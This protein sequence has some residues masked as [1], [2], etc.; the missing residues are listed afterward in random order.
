MMS[1]A[2][3]KIQGCRLST[4]YCKLPI[5]SKPVAVSVASTQQVQA[6]MSHAVA[7]AKKATARI[8]PPA[9]PTYDIKRVIKEVLL[10][11]AG[12]RGDVT[13]IATIPPDVQ[14]EAQFLAKDSGVIAGIEMA[15]M[16]FKEVDP[17]LKVDW[18]VEDGNSLSK[19]LHFGSVFGSARSILTAERV[20]LNFMQRMSGIATLTKIRRPIN[21][22]QCQSHTARRARRRSTTATQMM[23]NSVLLKDE[24]QEDTSEE[25][26][27]N[28]V[29]EAASA[30]EEARVLSL[31]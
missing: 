19:G 5:S 21:P 25:E 9:H 7:S 30:L 17:A 13:S 24:E 2:D 23:K 31:L 8:S 15:N 29:K 3:F 27:P 16:I 1:C 10:E 6:T 18:S 28:Q 12:E 22:E 20:V 11:D 26:A 4:S 14:A